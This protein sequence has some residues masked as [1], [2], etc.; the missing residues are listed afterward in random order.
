MDDVKENNLKAKISKLN[1]DVAALSAKDKW[2]RALFMVLF[3]VVST[4]VRPII[5]AMALIQFF[6][7]LFTNNPNANLL[8]FSESL[9][10]FAYQ[11][12]LYITYGT[13]EKPF[14]FSSWPTQ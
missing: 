3:V 13:Q 11:I 10:R 6:F 2:V 1:I 7:V 14:P 9:C 4:F 5:F 8:K 12:Y